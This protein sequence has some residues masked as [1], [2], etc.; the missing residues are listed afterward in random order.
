ME[1]IQKNRG[2]EPAVSNIVPDCVRVGV[3]FRL[4]TWYQRAA[5]RSP[6]AAPA[7]LELTRILCAV[8]SESVPPGPSAT[9]AS[10]KRSSSASI[11]P[12]APFAGTESGWAVV[13][14]AIDELESVGEAPPGLVTLTTSIRLRTRLSG[15][16]T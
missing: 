1:G 7:P 4:P 16:T 14:R 6:P 13:G 5:S 9:I 10:K 15:P 12:T 11:P 8:Q 3:V 2:L